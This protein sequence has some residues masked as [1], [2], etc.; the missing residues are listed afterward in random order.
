MKSNFGVGLLCGVM[1]MIA[2]VITLGLISKPRSPEGQ[3]LKTNDHRIVQ[4]SDGSFRIQNY[5]DIPGWK[6]LSGIKYK[7]YEEAKEGLDYIEAPTP[8]K[9]V[10]VKVFPK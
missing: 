5:W 2:V 6:D 3:K 1:L 9:P 10:I 8:A 7:S 4:Y